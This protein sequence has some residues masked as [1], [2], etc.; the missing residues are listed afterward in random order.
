MNID[1]AVPMLQLRQPDVYIKWTLKY[2]ITTKIQI[3]TILDYACSYMFW[4]NSDTGSLKKW[5]TTCR[6]PSEKKKSCLPKRMY[7]ALMCI[8]LHETWT[9]IYV[10]SLTFLSHIGMITCI[11]G[12][13][14]KLL[15]FLLYTW[16]FQQA[17]LWM[18]LILE[19]LCNVFA[20]TFY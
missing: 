12:F 18:E 20:S 1:F 4:E 7:Y 2:Y 8:R 13:I 15:L 16:L 10:N 3:Q 9:V 14:L 11:F 19:I 6:W 17:C 5:L